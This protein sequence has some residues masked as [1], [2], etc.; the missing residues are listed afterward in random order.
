MSIFWE[1]IIYVDVYYANN[2][3][4]RETQVR[5]DAVDGFYVDWK[6]EKKILIQHFF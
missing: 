2:G 6:W 1:T 4:V 5:I 3:K